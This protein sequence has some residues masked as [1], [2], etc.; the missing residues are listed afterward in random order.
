V[1]AVTY[2]PAT[3]DDAALAS[4]VMTRAYP[5]LPQDPVLTRYRWERVRSGYE[6]ARFLADRGGEPI[7]FTDLGQN[8]PSATARLRCGWTNRNTSWSW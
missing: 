4:D 8:F 2:R 5:S 6:S 7:A 3:L 1:S